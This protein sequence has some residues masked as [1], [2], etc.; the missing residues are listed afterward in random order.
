[1]Q[2]RL[3]KSGMGLGSA[4]TMAGGISTSRYCTPL[5]A[6]VAN[7]TPTKVNITFDNELNATLSDKSA[8]LVANHSISSIELD[9]TKKI[10]T[11]TLTTAVLVFDSIYL[12]YVT[13]AVNPLKSLKGGNSVA[14]FIM[15]ITNNVVDDG[16]T[17]DEFD[18]R[19]IATITKAD[20]S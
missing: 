19:A 16:D 14:S 13:P 10:L 12:F 11:L 20:L 1:M 6:V 8:F 18:C 5:S 3:R 17:V 7:T 2:N 4:L 15:S 9:A